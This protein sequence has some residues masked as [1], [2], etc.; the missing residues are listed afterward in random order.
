MVT[1][2]ET[3]SADPE[4]SDLIST[5]ESPSLRMKEIEIIEKQIAEIFI[6]RYI[7]ACSLESSIILREIMIARGFNNPKIVE[8]WKI[9]D[10]KYIIRHY[11]IQY[12]KYNLDI[13]TY[14][15]NM[16]LHKSFTPPAIRL[17]QDGEI[18]YEEGCTLKLERI[19]NK[20][21]EEREKLVELEKCFRMYKKTKGIKKY[22]Y[23][24]PKFIK[25]FIKSRTF[26]KG[27]V[28]SDMLP[29]C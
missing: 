3:S 19:D 6:K 4:H 7:L 18:P 8:G 1:H 27:Y 10:S 12:D 25:R 22:L 26:E 16:Q 24:C 2:I 21:S 14:I 23:T 5:Y 29:S 15:Y 20:T 17:F 13:G 28:L 11:W 9:E